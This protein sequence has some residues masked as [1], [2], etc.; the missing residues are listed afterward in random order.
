MERFWHG[1]T[2]FFKFIKEFAIMMGTLDFLGWMIAAFISGMALLF[3]MSGIFIIAERWSKK[4]G[5]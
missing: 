5:K 4:H 2:G 1:F 3:I